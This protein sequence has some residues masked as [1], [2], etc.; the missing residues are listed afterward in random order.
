MIGCLRIRVRKQ[1]IIA[2]YFEFETQGYKTFFM[3]NSTEHVISTA[4]KNL[5]YWKI[6]IFLALKLSKVIFILLIDVKMPTIVG[7]LTCM[8][9]INKISSSIEISMNKIV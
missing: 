3:L 5:L 6:K 1:P 7:I 8:S 9:I 4:N 2:L